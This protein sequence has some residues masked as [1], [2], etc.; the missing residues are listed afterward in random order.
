MIK[1]ILVMI[2]LGANGAPDGVKLVMTSDAEE[3]TAAINAARQVPAIVEQVEHN[4]AAFL[5]VPMT[6]DGKGV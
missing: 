4:R 3:C 6:I 1:V 2:S 5:C